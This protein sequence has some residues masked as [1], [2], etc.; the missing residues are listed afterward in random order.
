MESMQTT[1]AKSRELEK[2]DIAD[3]Q[4]A[5]D[6][7]QVEAS[8]FPPVEIKSDEENPWPPLSK[9]IA[10]KRKR[11][12]SYIMLKLNKNHQCPG[13]RDRRWGTGSGE[14]SQ[15]KRS[16]KGAAGEWRGRKEHRRR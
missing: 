7:Q 15:Y 9:Q 14:V 11:G 6:D 10:F 12:N 1:G 3:Y 16:H 8:K 5:A 4:Q 13:K 2:D